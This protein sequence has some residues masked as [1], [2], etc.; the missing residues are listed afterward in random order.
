MRY[1][2]AKERE[3]IPL[4][5]VAENEAET[6]RFYIKGW[7]EL[8]GSGG[9]YV[10]VHKRPIDEQPYICTTTVSEDGYVDW[11][12]HNEDCAYAGNGEAQFSYVINN[13]IAKSVIYTT[14]ILRSLG[15]AGE[16]PEPYDTR[17]Q[18]LIDTV[19]EAQEVVGEAAS[20]SAN[21]PVINEQTG[22][23]DLW[24]GSEYVDSG[25]PS[26]GER[27]KE[28]IFW[29]NS[30]LTLDYPPK[31][32]TTVAEIRAALNNGQF[33]VVKITSS[34]PDKYLPFME[35]QDVTEGQA[36]EYVYVNGQWQWVTTGGGN[37]EI[38]YFG[39][40][41]ASGYWH[42]QTL[43]KNTGDST[44]T[45]S[46]YS[47]Q[48]T[49]ARKT[50]LQNYVQT[51][52]KVNNKAL[53]SNVTL[54]AEDIGYD[55]TLVSH[56]ANSVGAKIKKY[57]DELS[58][59]IPNVTFSD[60]VV[61]LDTTTLTFSK[62]G[63]NEWYVS[64]A[65]QVSKANLVH[66]PAVYKIT[67][68]GT[69]YECFF[70]HEFYKKSSALG[71]Y[72]CVVVGNSEVIGYNKKYKTDAPFAVINGRNESSR[73][74]T[75]VYTTSDA[76][77]HTIKI[78]Y[79]SYTK[80]VVDPRFY[81]NIDL[82]G[83]TNQPAVDN[84]RGYTFAG[85]SVA[86]E[87]SIACGHGSQA[88][89]LYCVALGMVNIANG[90]GCFAEGVGTIAGGSSN[91]Y[92]AHSEGGRTQAIGYYS[93]AEGQNTQAVGNV[94]HAE[95]SDTVASGGRAHA[96]GDYTIANHRAQHVF[97]QYNV[98]DQSSAI[99]NDRGNYVEI[100]GNGTEENERSNA[101]TLDWNGNEALQGSLT[102][103]K[104]TVDETTITAAQLK[105]LLALLNV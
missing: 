65:I 98:A 79:V 49:L 33:P 31:P 14:V 18:E 85:G 67:W 88:R 92:G 21:P 80:E 71:F 94:S 2:I 58:E 30:G 48:Q 66:S 97:G 13:K 84:I 56:T 46:S 40:V 32:V 68:D 100:V 17:I 22:N 63:D 10:L 55:G 64:D 37:Y 61:L 91:P 57:T 83:A 52:R 60:P 41:D 12:I 77:Q 19:V 45:W 62:D 5:R 105:A 44:E 9:T 28:D 20:Y 102:L 99:A 8:Y 51:T 27:G 101:R 82:F 93:H 75:Y 87:G 53:S 38:Y 76:E 69:E 34:Y 16:L 90:Q 24:D 103:G 86:G 43:K 7:E 59:K 39:Y 42:K 104:G 1:V 25:Y 73:N 74:S 95:G 6:V 81:A 72:D 96:E 36:E 4:G 89:G 11:V 15:Q 50:D 47:H 78:S 3:K 70:I 23:W 35:W 29:V 26:R 54:T